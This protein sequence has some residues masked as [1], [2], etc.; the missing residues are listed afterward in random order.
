MVFQ[1]FSAMSEVVFSEV[2]NRIQNKLLAEI[3]A[4]M[5][6]WQQYRNKILPLTDDYN[7]Q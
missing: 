3:I 2:R 1:L 6:Y 7:K 5:E 4:V